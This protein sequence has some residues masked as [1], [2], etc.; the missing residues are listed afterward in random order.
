MPHNKNIHS[1]DWNHIQSKDNHSIEEL[2]YEEIQILKEY[3]RQQSGE[4]EFLREFPDKDPS[5]YRR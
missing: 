3:E 1:T 2:S 5:A 4:E